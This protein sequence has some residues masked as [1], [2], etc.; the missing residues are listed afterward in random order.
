MALA[1]DCIAGQ[2]VRGGGGLLM[3]LMLSSHFG[4]V[5]GGGLVVARDSLGIGKI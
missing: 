5:Y 3:A 1:P 2:I 4:R